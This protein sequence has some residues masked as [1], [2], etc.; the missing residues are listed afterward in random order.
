MIVRDWFDRTNFCVGAAGLGFTLWAVAAAT[1][2]KKA[3]QRAELSV[4]RHNA[5]G[6]FGFLA[7]KARE[8]HGF[9]EN[10]RL[11]EA[12]IRTADIRSDLATALGR[13]ADFLGAKIADLRAMQVDHK[14]MTDG[15][16]PEQDFLSYSERIR[17]LKITGAILELPSRNWGELRSGTERGSS[18]G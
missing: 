4:L 8:L 9:V 13:H 11:P 3:A 14:L 18:N 7:H 12:R 2:A 16:N 15:L 5:E 1:S 17:L 6:D 10:D